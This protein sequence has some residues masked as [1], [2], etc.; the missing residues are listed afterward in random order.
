MLNKHCEVCYNTKYH[1][2]LKKERVKIMIKIVALNTVKDG[3]KQKFIERAKPLIAASNAEAGCEFYVL[4]EDV[5]NG[6]I[7]T[8]IEGWKDEEAI[9]IHKNSE[10]FTT[11]FPTLAEL[12]SKEMQINLYKEIN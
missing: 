7:L 4:H 8:F 5:N 6:N 11:I 1:N 9:E 12:C 10:H 2:K 3:E